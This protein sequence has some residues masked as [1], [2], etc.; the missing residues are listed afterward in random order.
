MHDRVSSHFRTRTK[1]F[2]RFL[3]FVLILVAGILLHGRVAA[4]VAVA[5][6]NTSAASPLNSFTSG[7]AEI[8]RYII[9]AGLKYGVDPLLIFF[10]FLV[11]ESVLKTRSPS[12]TTHHTT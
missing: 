3:G 2:L 12:Q 7:S 4:P 8:D 5:E 10:F 11:G 9:Q 6:T 1:V